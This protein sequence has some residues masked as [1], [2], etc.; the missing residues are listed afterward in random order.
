[1][2]LIYFFG[3]ILIA[4]LSSFHSEKTS[5]NYFGQ[6][7]PDTTPK[8]FAPQII[9]LD[10]RFESRGAFSQDGKAFYFTVVN[11]NFT[12]QKI[13]FTEYKSG[14]WST[15]DTAS[16]SK[17]FNNHEPFFSYDSKKLYFS[18]DREKDTL[19]NRRDLFVT[20]RHHGTWSEP[21]KL[22]KPVN[23]DYTELFF[24]QS[25]NGTIYFTS[26]RPGGIGKWDI[27]FVKSNNGKYEKLENIDSPINKLYAWDP[28]IAPDESY[29]IF[30]AGRTDGYGQ[31]DLYI[32]YKKNS[33]W[34]EPKNLGNKI[35]TKANE[36]GPFLSPDNKY[37]FFCRHDGIK[38]DIYWV[39][40]NKYL[41]HF[42]DSGLSQSFIRKF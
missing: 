27:Y 31:S 23:S 12:S 2:K 38:G 11:S 14:K 3:L 4:I 36:F 33:V 21:T 19:Q 40:L 13:F 18:S 22:K 35:N 7:P 1:M 5:I 24:D 15:P 41:S 37:L 17:K 26:D 20:E 29:L 28:C 25:K 34:T 6:I 30:G 10:N 32:S 9:C 42:L 8:I 16:F 39:D